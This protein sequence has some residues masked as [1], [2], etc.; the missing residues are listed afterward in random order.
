M[1]KGQWN[2]I[3]NRPNS[4]LMEEVSHGAEGIK[5]KAR[6]TQAREEF[7]TE[8]EKKQK[9]EEETKKQCV[10]FATQLG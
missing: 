8:K 1:K 4:D 2:G 5:R 6:E 10:L 3:T 7:N 9:T